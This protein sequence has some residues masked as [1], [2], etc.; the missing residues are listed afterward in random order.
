MTASTLEIIATSL[1]A[2]ALIHTFSSSFFEHLAHKH[3][4]HAGL[5]HLIGE[6]EAIFGFWAMILI[7]AM[8]IVYKDSR[9]AVEYLESRN[10]TEPLFV[11][12]IMVVAA[13]KPILHFASHIV[14]VLAKTVRRIGKINEQTST[15]FLTLSLVP[16]L[17]S[18]ITEPGAMTLAALLLKDRLFSKT[19]NTSLMYLTIGV[20]FV[21][22]SIGG[23][24]TN[25]AAPPILMVASAWGWDTTYVFQTFG[26]KAAITVLI[27]AL[28]ITIYCH[29]KLPANID[30]QEANQKMP[31]AVTL[32][33]LFFLVSIVI[34][35]HHPIV[36]M[37][38][39]L[40]FLG[41]THAYQ[42]YQNRLLL[43]EALMVA[44]FLAG[45][46]VLGGMQQWWL[47]PILEKMSNTFVFYGAIGLTAMT[48]NA[49]LTYLGSL[50]QGTSD[51]FKYALVAGAIT[52]GGLTVIANAPNPAGL[53]LL[54]EHFPEESV[55]ALRLFIAALLPTIISIITF[56]LF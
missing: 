10:Y 55:S 11:F 39:L 41:Y 25:F 52:G 46:V 6:I 31:W 17:G 43:K 24:L 53:S 26:I 50:V 7:I 28:L 36:F 40:F 32:I 42:K 14:S 54:K 4:Q 5:C 47:Q 13:S 34:F 35:A 22:V 12:A 49:A 48:D 19:K 23:A 29:K 33:H 3:P 38:L 8:A 44:F 56:Q 51:G 37:G 1:F 20:L 21:N 9:P 30:K 2:I 15:Y 16:L 45:L 18:F 27:N